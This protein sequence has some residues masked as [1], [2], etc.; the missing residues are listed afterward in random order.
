MFASGQKAGFLPG[1]R[2]PT[3]DEALYMLDAGLVLEAVVFDIHS[4]RASFQ[5]IQSSNADFPTKS[6]DSAVLS[7]QA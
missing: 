4:L 2:S 3:H 6:V 1:Y 5:A 7:W